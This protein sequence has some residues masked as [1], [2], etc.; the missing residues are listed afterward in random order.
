M[1]R[2]RHV[3]DEPTA[4]RR[5]FVGAEKEPKLERRYH[6]IRGQIRRYLD[7]NPTRHRIRPALMTT[8]LRVRRAIPISTSDRTLVRLICRD[9]RPRPPIIGGILK[10]ATIVPLSGLLRLEF[11]IMP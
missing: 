10:N 4:I 7:P 11:V 2:N 3:V 9:V 8:N 1:R 6:I 5:A